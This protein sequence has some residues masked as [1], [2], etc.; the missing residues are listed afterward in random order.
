MTAILEADPIAQFKA[1]QRESWATFAPL[2][3]MTMEPAGH[4][5]DWAK[6]A[7]GDKVL[8][9]GCGTGVVAITARQRGAKVT[10][11]DLTPE[12]LARARVNAQQAGCA[13]ITWREG[14]AEQ[15]PYADGEFDVV[16]SQYGHMFAPRPAVTA[17]EMLR[18]LRPGG[19]IAFSTW[20]ADH[21]IGRLFAL[22]GK[23]LPPLP[24][25]ASPPT[26]WGEPAFIR[27]TLGPAVRDLM[28]DRRTLRFGTL[29][30]AHYRGLIEVTSGPIIR[31]LQ[32]L[33]N[34]PSKTAQ[35]R[36]EIDGIVA[37]YM[38]GN[39]VRQSYLMTRA[40]KT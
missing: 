38:D 23:Y 40:T 5:V 13:D 34:D 17:K 21:V 36:S 7:A 15:L 9:V 22:T 19:R 31:I 1:R 39:V 24:A 33:A 16:V 14:D 30:L 32:A 35:L 29:G 6:I 20:P 28:F 25:G 37:P 18:V 3:T 8:D 2:E 12:L 4:L 27:E 10:G 26:V 11:L